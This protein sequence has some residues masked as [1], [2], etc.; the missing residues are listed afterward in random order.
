[1]TGFGKREASIHGVTY[2]TE[3]KSINHR[4]REVVTRIPRHLAFAEEELKALVGKHCQ[5]GRIEI[6]GV[7]SEKIRRSVGK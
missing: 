4:F 3:V 1:M 5:R 7:D 2:V 6:S